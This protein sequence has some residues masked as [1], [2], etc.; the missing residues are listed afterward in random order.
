MFLKVSQA[1]A[2]LFAGIVALPLGA[3][4]EDALYDTGPSQDSSYVRFVNA[5]ASPLTITGQGG[6]KIELPAGD[7]ARVTKYQPVKAGKA[8][9]AGVANASGKDS[10]TVTVSSGEFATVLITADASG[11]PSIAVLK[12]QPTDFNALKSSLAFYNADPACSAAELVAG[13]NNTVV[14]SA[15]APG[16]FARR[17]V[18]PIAIGVAARC[19]GQPAGNAVDMGQLAAGG[20]YSIFVVA[21][22]ANG[23]SL[24]SVKD[25]TSTFKK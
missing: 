11:R 21:T 14:F 7:N 8:L 3:H 13:A 15:Q 5:T 22:G 18:N 6:A 23:H 1:A 20:R 19:G 16:T 10:V 4:A 17:E 12:E 25:A 24:F 2:F 9:A